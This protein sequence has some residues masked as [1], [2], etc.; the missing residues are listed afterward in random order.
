M[1]EGTNQEEKRISS[2][3]ILRNR[4]WLINIIWSGVNILL[5][6]WIIFTGFFVLL[7]NTFG[8][9]FFSIG[10]CCSLILQIR[11]TM[12]WPNRLP[13]FIPEPF[14][15]TRTTRGI[16]I[17]IIIWLPFHLVISWIIRTNPWLL[18]LILPGVLALF[19][20]IFGL[21]IF[22]TWFSLAGLIRLENR[23]GIRIV[24]QGNKFIALGQ[25][26][27]YLPKAGNT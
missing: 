16:I 23:E 1:D 2:G 19:A 27:V 5:V 6:W 3:D 14:G 9:I 22:G 26:E 11:Y 8:L 15:Q 18:Q 4:Y 13:L 10:V 21:L 7:F 17:F 24:K 12:G 25:D 20:F